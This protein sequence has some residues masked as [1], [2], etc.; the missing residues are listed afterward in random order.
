MLELLSSNSFSKFLDHCLRFQEDI[1]K[2]NDIKREMFYILNNNVE[3]V[4]VGGIFNLLDFI[5]NEYSLFYT[6]NARRKESNTELSSYQKRKRQENS[7]KFSKQLLKTLKH[8]RKKKRH[9]LKKKGRRK[10]SKLIKS[11]IKSL[12]KKKM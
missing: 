1:D 6:E 12:L 8:Q 10:E 3:D 9:Q 4:S 5:F 7:L 2:S 11:K